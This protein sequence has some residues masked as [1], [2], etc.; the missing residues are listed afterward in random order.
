[1]E[2]L[3]CLFTDVGYSDGNHLNET[4][5]EIKIMGKKNEKTT[6]HFLFLQLETDNDEND[7][8]EELGRLRCVL[9]TRL[10]E[11]LIDDLYLL[12]ERYKYSPSM[13]C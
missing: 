4:Q 6:N 13:T 1:M 11:E 12:S 2:K 3:S 5:K 9:D 10:Y 7:L 8:C